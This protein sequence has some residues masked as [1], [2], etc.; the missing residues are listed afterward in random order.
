MRFFLTMLSWA[1]A[2]LLLAGC[3][4]LT[5]VLGDDD[6]GGEA[7]DDDDVV[8]DDDDTTGSA[9]DDDDSVGDDD[10]SGGEADDDDDTVGEPLT[11][12]VI[13]T[14]DFYVTGTLATVDLDTRVAT[15]AVAAVST[16]AFLAFGEDRVVVLDGWG[17][18]TVTGYNHPD[19]G[20]S[21]WTAAMTTSDN[22]RAAAVLGGKV[23]VALYGSADLAVLDA[24]TGDVLSFIDLSLYADGDGLPECGAVE[25]LGGYLWVSCHRLDPSWQPSPIGGILLKIDP[26]TETVLAGWT[27]YSGL[28]CRAFPG[29]DELVCHEGVDMDSAWMPVYEG[30]IFTFDPVAETFGPDLFSESELAAN[31]PVFAFGPDGRGLIAATGDASSSVLCADLTDG[32]VTTLIDDLG[33]ISAMAVNDR[34]EAFVLNRSSWTSPYTGPYGFSVL[35]LSPCSDLGGGVI[36]VGAE[37]YQLTFAR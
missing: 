10:D 37:P 9:D 2:G 31:I 17:F 6:S 27:A 29:M 5:D 34:G 36:G 20:T 4:T 7:G 18:D 23:F 16:D 30:A 35:D 15:P 3:E 1:C 22:P 33:W 19:Y 32:S 13:S 24:T 14:T 11:H 12:A 26:I 8:G 25:E 21:E 28:T